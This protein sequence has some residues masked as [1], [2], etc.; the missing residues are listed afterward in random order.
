MEELSNRIRAAICGITPDGL[1]NVWNNTKLKLN[2]VM[3]VA[4]GLIENAM[5]YYIFFVFLLALL[6]M[7]LDES[8]G[9]KWNMAINCAVFLSPQYCYTTYASEWMNK[10]HHEALFMSIKNDLL[11]GKGTISNTTECCIHAFH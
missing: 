2:Y 4:G 1:T 3:E 8:L 9:T 7:T 11:I 5:D 10:N 6:T